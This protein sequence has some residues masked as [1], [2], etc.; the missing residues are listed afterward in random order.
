MRPAK[1]ALAAASLLAAPAHAGGFLVFQQGARGMGL[2]G[3]YAAQSDDPS[4]IFHNPAGV[5]FLEGQRLY[6]GASL[7]H[8]QLDFAGTSPFPGPGVT[9]SGDAP[10]SL[11]PAFDYSQQLSERMV[12]GVGL[13]LPFS[14]RTRWLNRE[15]SFS[16]RF[17]AKSAEIQSYSLNPTLAYKLAD[18]LSLG[19]GLDVR[20][21]SLELERN[22]A[23]PVNPFTQKIQ[24]AAAL[25]LASGQQLG[26][27][28]DVGVLAKPSEDL[29]L[30]ASYRHKVKADFTG[31]AAFTRIATGNAQLDTLLDQRLPAGEVPLTLGIEFPSL[32]SLGAQYAWR[33][34]IFAAGVDFQGWSSFDELELA[35]ESRP[36]LSRVVEPGYSNSQTY[37]GGAERRLGDSWT[38]R[39]GYFFD[40]TPA[41]PESVSP[42][43]P[44]ASSHVVALGGTWRSGRTRVDAANWLAFSNERST[45]GR[46][47]EGYDGTYKSFSF[48][49]SIS[50]GITF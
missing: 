24:D 3:A 17:I 39:G 40:K 30:G 2:A 37:R 21:S 4:A 46:S 50:V 8:S 20:L 27:G 47:R 34:W 14:L 49:L 23:V 44:A 28:F 43:L 33:D 25:R 11:P 31:S 1:L 45:E 35:L 26:F 15:T 9:E 7:V 41:P 38:A 36:E 10:L 29:A 13:H 22:V 5:A 12:V 18:R 32:I 6:L 19:F 16:G 42:L 48:S